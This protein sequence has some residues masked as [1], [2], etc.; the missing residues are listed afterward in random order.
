MNLYKV[1][2]QGMNDVVFSGM[3]YG[4]S[5]VVARDPTAAYKIVR[6]F[7]DSQNIGFIDKRQLKSIEL[8]AEDKL[9]AYPYKLYLE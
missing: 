3:C 8:I 5:Y 7:L 4:T 2:L 9:Y 6:N 1:T